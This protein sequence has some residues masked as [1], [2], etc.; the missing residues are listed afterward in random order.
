M[1][2]TTSTRSTATAVAL[3]VAGAALATYPA[4][5]PYGPESGL[6]G[7]ADLGSGAWVAAHVLGMVGFVA[8]AVALRV[9]AV[10]APWRWTGQPVRQ[11]E[12]RAWLAVSLLLPYY[13]AEAYGL[14]AVGRHALETGDVGLL[15][16]ADSFRYAP[17]EIG[18]FS[19][20]LLALLM[21]GGR[22]AHG[23]WRTGPVGRVGG[24]LAGLGLATY[25]PQFFGTPGLRVLHGLV[26]GT[27]LLLMAVATWRAPRGGR[28]AGQRP[29]GSRSAGEPGDRPVGALSR[30]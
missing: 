15:E 12:T 28:S 30:P 4:L 18:S 3:A 10:A 7:A 9:A 17:F 29:G 8:L 25:L 20:G 11:A 13:G 19:L 16:V 26:L 23:M 5:R 24:L 6:E 2:S 27:G 21:V 22:L 1:D 14:N